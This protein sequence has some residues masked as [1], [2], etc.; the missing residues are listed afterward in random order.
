MPEPTPTPPAETALLRV[1]QGGDVAAFEPLVDADLDHPASLPPDFER[2][3]ALVVRHL[4]V[5][6]NNGPTNIG[7]GGQ[8]RVPVRAPPFS[9]P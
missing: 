3:L 8:P 4:Q 2:Q 7:G 1:V 5:V 6:V 9:K